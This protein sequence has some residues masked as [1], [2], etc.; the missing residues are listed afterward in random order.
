MAL[1]DSR[2][3][4]TVMMCGMYFAQGVPWGY[5]VT[6]LINYVVEQGAT[7]AE[8]AKLTAVVLIPWTFK[9]IWAPLIDTMTLRSMGRRRVWIIG[10][11]FMMAASLLGILMVGDASID[12]Q[13]LYWMFFVHNCFASLQDV[14]TDA[15]AV[16]VLPA[17]EQ[18]RMNGMMWGSKLIG[19]A[20][21][22]VAMAEIIDRWGLMPSVWV[23]FAI[24]LFIMLLP[25][26]LL[27]RPG[28]KRFPWSRGKASGLSSTSSLR[29]PVAVAK[30]LLQAFSLITTAVFFVFGLT[31]NLGWGIVEVITKTLYIQ[32]LD[33]RSVEVSRVMGYAVFPEL[34][35]AIVGGYVADRFGRRKVIV[36]GLGGYGLM[37]LVFAACEPLWQKTWFSTGYLLLNPGL[38]AMGAV[39]F[40]SMGMKIS[41]T[42]AAAT[43]FTIYMTLSNVGHVVGNQLVGPLTSQYKFSYPQLLSTAGVLCL[44]PL[45]LL[46]FVRPTRVDEARSRTAKSAATASAGAAST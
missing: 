46:P 5:M 9:I 8:A 35:G 40:L 25:L 38:L 44:V 4:R 18:G 10:A 41:W 20:V 34:I 6:A 12:I 3:Q 13:L 26:L 45:L 31:Q 16:D 21:G 28:E 32:E 36:V 37:A 22:A 29:S 30:D 17:H 42:R 23:Q 24:L 11:E 14:A 39:G 7:P 43:V 2:K 27:E 19:K 1:V 33:W 15:L